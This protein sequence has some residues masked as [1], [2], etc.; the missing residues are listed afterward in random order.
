MTVV[1][2]VIVGFLA[3]LYE[4]SNT[5]TTVKKGNVTSSAPSKT[6]DAMKGLKF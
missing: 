2:I 1:A 6:E 3:L 5:P 4:A